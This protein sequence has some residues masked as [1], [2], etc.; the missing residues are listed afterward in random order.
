MQPV[1][2]ATPPGGPLSGSMLVGATVP[3]GTTA[4][5]TAFKVSGSDKLIAPGSAPAALTDPATGAV[6]GTLSVKPDGTFTFTPAPGYTGP[7]PA[8]TVTVASSDGQSRDV[9]LSLT[10]NALLRDGSESPTLAAGSGALSLNVLDN[11]QPP[12]GCTV[13]VTGFS[14]PGSTTVYPAGPTPVTVVDPVS[15]R[16]AGTVVVQ[17]NGALTFTPAAGFT[18]QV[19]AV[20]YTVLSSD[21]QTSPGA[22]AATVLPGE[23]GWSGLRVRGL[24]QAR[25]HLG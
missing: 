13:N 23:G 2:A 15:G 7:V 14:L 6:V 3:P 11:A 19:P 10:V 9:P 22:V 24:V 1:T 18:G 25:C 4:S 12:A 5:V 21:G 16:A 20:T 17:P 8:V